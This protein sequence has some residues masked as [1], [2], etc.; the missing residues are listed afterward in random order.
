M[1]LLHAYLGGGRGVENTEELFQAHARASIVAC[2]GLF[3]SEVK[4]WREEAERICEACNA[5]LPEAQIA[6]DYKAH[7][8]LKALLSLSSDGSDYDTSAL[9]LIDDTAEGGVAERSWKLFWRMANLCQFAPHFCMVAKRGLD[10]GLYAQLPRE[11]EFET[12]ETNA[13]WNEIFDYLLPDELELARQMAQ[14]GLPAPDDAG[15]EIAFADGGIAA[16]TLVW[17]EAR[18]AWFFAPDEEATRLFA[19]DGWKTF[20]GTAFPSEKDLERSGQ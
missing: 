1:L 14:S 12:V 17:R 7:E 18:V 5:S 15:V 10:E 13:R 3:S 4:T 9:L 8:H 20:T 6:C 2:K 16:A 11:E 19:E